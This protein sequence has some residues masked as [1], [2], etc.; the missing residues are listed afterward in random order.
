[1]SLDT[2]LKGYW[3]FNETSGSSAED[4]V[5][6]NNGTLQASSAFNSGGKLNYCFYTSADSSTAG[7]NIGTLSNLDISQYPLSIAAW[8]KTSSAFT[9]ENGNMVIFSNVKGGANYSGFSLNMIMGSTTG[10]R[11]KIQFNYRNNAG[12]DYTLT[13][14]A[15]Y[16]DGNY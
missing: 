14:T 6:S 7:I 13:T 11:G 5:L 9:Q 3:K 2:S 4:Y 12:T 8:F 10:D 16:N 15:T 1:M